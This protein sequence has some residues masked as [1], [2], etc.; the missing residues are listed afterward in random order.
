MHIDNECA[1]DGKYDPTGRMKIYNLIRENVN[2]TK[3][4]IVWPIVQNY[5]AR[6]LVRKL[7]SLIVLMTT[8]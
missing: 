4:E 5:L 8:A 2:Q 6:N 7:G 3:G 1:S